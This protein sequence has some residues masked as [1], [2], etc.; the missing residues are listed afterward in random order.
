[1]PSGEKTR[2]ITGDGISLHSPRVRKSGWHGQP[3]EL[4]V[5]SG[6]QHCKTPFPVAIPMGQFCTSARRAVPLLQS[7]PLGTKPQR[8]LLL[9]RSPCHK[10]T[11]YPSISSSHR[12]QTRTALSLE[13]QPRRQGARPVIRVWVFWV[14]VF[15]LGF[16]R[17]L[18]FLSAQLCSC[19]P[20]RCPAWLLSC[21][22]GEHPQHQPRHPK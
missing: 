19:S 12:G 17:V 18:V 7:P 6:R 20:P 10:P 15:A 22:R 5:F 13:R 16:A 21:G 11:F 2:C 4:V 1:M 9:F 3:W 8:K 14:L